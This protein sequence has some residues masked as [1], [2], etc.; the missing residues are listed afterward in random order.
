MRGIS[1]IG[2]WP[3][4]ALALA[5]AAT[6]YAAPAIGDHP[7][8]L[9]GK[10][11]KG[12]EVRISERRG[13]VVVVSFWA[14][15]CGYCR[16]QLPVLETLQQAAGRERMEVVVV[17]FK[18]SPQTYRALVR[19]LRK[20]TVTLTHDRDGAI[21]DAY[22]VNAVVSWALIYPAGLA[23]VFI[24]RLFDVGGVGVLLWFALLALC[25]YGLY[26]TW[27]RYRSYE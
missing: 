6:A 4:L 10:T 7:P 11:P 17:N 20:L 1:A 18:E 23:S 3:G 12:E 19:D 25:S 24:D 9:L 14:S 27:T 21:S 22:G 26:W 15:W 13:K 5:L 2:I 8:D 16:K